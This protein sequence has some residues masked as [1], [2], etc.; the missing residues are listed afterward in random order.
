M[1]AKLRVGIRFRL[2]FA[3]AVFATLCFAAPPAVLAFGHGGNA[4][5][6]LSHADTINHGMNLAADK[7]TDHGHGHT[8]QGVPADHQPNCCGLYCLS[9]L[10]PAIE[11]VRE[12]AWLD[13]SFT[14]PAG[15]GFMSRITDNPDPPPIP[16][17]SV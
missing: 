3:L 4:L 7:A 11:T 1:L 8:H 9:A 2:A 10:M 14:P 6:C 5:Q 12:P 16:F 17:A 15:A 13:F